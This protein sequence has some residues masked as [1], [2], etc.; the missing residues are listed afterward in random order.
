MRATAR[1]AVTIA[2]GLAITAAT[3]VGAWQLTVKNRE[4]PPVADN[5][6]ARQAVTD[7]AKTNV[8]KVLTYR[9]ETVE[10]DTSAAAAVTT[11]D[12][13]AYYIRFARQIV[14]PTAR[15]KGV[16]T[17]ATVV[18]AGVESLTAQ[19]ASILVFINQNTTSRDKPTPEAQNSSVR[20]GMTKLN[21]TWLIDHFD[22]V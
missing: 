11:G 17:S 1:W 4:L 7:A 15:E 16:T 2:L 13:R 20:V 19:K 18:R 22:P 21:G 9:P 14:V 5:A 8:V 12:F 6:G 3:S 10:Q